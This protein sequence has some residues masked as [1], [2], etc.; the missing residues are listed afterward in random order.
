MNGCTHCQTAKVNFIGN[1]NLL[2]KIGNV[3]TPARCLLLRAHS[4]SNCA[5]ITTAHDRGGLGSRMCCPLN[6]RHRFAAITRMIY[7]HISTTGSTKC[8]T[9]LGTLR[10]A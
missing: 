9:R 3:R 2:T 1:L 6:L 10:G 4:V 7:P 5:L 8:A